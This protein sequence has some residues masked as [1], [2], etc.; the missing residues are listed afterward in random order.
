[1][2]NTIFLQQHNQNQAIRKLMPIIDKMAYKYATLNH[3]PYDEIKSC[4]LMGAYKAYVSFNGIG[5]IE[6]HAKR[7]MKSE[8]LH[9]LRDDV[10]L[11]KYRN[12]NM[13]DEDKERLYNV[14]LLYKSLS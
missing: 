4:C 13:S 10:S 9:Y 5:N 7:Y 2:N 6:G 14:S 11:I 12:D 1:M 8:I 3:K